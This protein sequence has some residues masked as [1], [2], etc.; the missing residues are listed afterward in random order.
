M[1]SKYTEY[2]WGVRD[3]IIN[4]Y[5]GNNSLA[6]FPIAHPLSPKCNLPTAIVLFYLGNATP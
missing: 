3:L 1:R 4:E 5:K 2:R 6:T